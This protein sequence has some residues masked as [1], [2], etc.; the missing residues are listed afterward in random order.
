MA[1]NQVNIQRAI[2]PIIS[3]VAP[4]AMHETLPKAQISSDDRV[5]EMTDAHMQGGGYFDK[6][7]DLEY[8]KATQAA[9]TNNCIGLSWTGTGLYWTGFL[10]PG[11]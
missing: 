6:E 11:F 4:H 5:W 1:I 8:S 10:V 2:F 7:Q 3:Y 9:P